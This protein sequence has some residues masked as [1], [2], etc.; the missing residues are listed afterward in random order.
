MGKKEEEIIEKISELLNF[1]KKEKRER[2]IKES[3][4]HEDLIYFTFLI[5][6]V[7]IIKTGN[8]SIDIIHQETPINL[9]EKILIIVETLSNLLFSLLPF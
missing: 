6:L 9:V 2:M 8:I 3:I 7:L 4:K 1:L 5:S